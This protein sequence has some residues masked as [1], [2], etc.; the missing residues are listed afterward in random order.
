MYTQAGILPTGFALPLVELFRSFVDFFADDDAS[1]DDKGDDDTIIDDLDEE[2]DDNIFGKDDEDGEDDD[3]KD[4]KD[5]KKSKKS[6][7]IV[8]KQK[9][10]QLYKKT[11][12]ELKDLRKQLE[13]KEA[14]GS[15]DAKAKQEREA[16]AFIRGLIAEEL[17][18]RASK[19]SEFQQQLDE[20]LADLL[21][22]NEDLT[23]KQILEVVEDLGV[24]PKQA[25][26]AIRRYQGDGGKGKKPKPNVPRGKRGGGGG[27]SDKDDKAKKPLTLEEASKLAKQRLSQMGNRS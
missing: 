2:E 7:A 20:E 21:E 9:Y 11:D 14:G 4:E 26:A 17:E 5:D 8:Q 25:V 24:T 10:R 19:D 23:E 1:D 16:K 18:A 6:S 3:E 12:K 15:D 27:E 22:D 13:E